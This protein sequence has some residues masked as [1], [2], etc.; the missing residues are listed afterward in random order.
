MM[1]IKEISRFCTILLLTWLLTTVSAIAKDGKE[2]NDGNNKFANQELLNSL[3]DK[4]YNLEKNKKGKINIVH[5]GDSHIQADIFTNTI[6][7]ALQDK[8][9]NGG[10][11]FTFP[12]RLI[13]TNGPSA[14]SYVSS[15][16][17]Q[18]QR[19]I[20]PVAD[21]GVGLSGIALFT[22]TEDFVVQLSS[23]ERY[24]FN[25]LKIIYPTEAPQYK[26]CISS[27]PVITTPSSTVVTGGG[28]TSSSVKYV[29]HKVKSGESLST[30]ARKYRVSVAQ[31]KNANGLRSNMIHAGK[32][33]KIPSKSAKVSSVQAKKK[34]TS[35]ASKSKVSSIKLNNDVDFASLEEKPYHSIFKADSLFDHIAVL[36]NGKNPTY[37]LNGFVIENDKPGVIYHTIGVNGAK[38]SD[39]IKYPLFF[40]QLPILKPDMVILSFGTNESFGKLSTT[41]YL[42][43]L[44]EFVDNVRRMCGQDIT[45]LVMTPPPSLFRRS[46]N[47]TYVEDYSSA[48]VNLTN[49]PVWD[50]Y[51]RMGG[52]SAIRAKGENSSLIGRDNVHYTV[53]GYQIQGEMFAN[54]FINAYSNFKKKR[55]IGDTFKSTK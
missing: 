37:N 8:F 27:S 34:K 43:Q 7:Q 22:G 2:N 15:A 30:I 29:Y 16:V 10:W 23:D 12:Y 51:T 31:I 20:Y 33:L 41:E 55:T 53:K 48:L 50:L 14:V 45:I 54:D 46:R 38:L 4:L 49:Y 24:K 3:F 6:R 28:T 13:G 21:V 36:P 18:S 25:T 47:N 9:G 17:W 11:G 35:V 52:L 19:N 32:S 5:I 40:K 26:V 42:F 1:Q 44:K 39:Y